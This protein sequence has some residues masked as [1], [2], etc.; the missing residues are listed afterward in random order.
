MF[1][2]LCFAA[3]PYVLGS[4]WTWVISEAVVVVFLQVTDSGHPVNPKR[5]QNAERWLIKDVSK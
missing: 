5:D 1:P 2:L 4:N 3:T